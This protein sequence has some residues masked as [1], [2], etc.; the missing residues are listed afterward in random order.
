MGFLVSVETRRQG[1]EFHCRHG[2]VLPPEG[3]E[4]AE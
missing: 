2:S 3:D 4:V 1:L